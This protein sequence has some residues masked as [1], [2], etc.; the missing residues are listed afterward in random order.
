MAERMSFI[1]GMGHPCGVEFHAAEHIKEHPEFKWQ[2]PLLRDVKANPWTVVEA[3][4][5]NVPPATR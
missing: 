2:S 3:T 1:A 4:T 5:A